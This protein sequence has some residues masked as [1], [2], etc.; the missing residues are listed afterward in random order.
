MYDTQQFIYQYLQKSIYCIFADIVNDPLLD[1]NEVL[2]Q[3][4][5]NDEDDIPNFDSNYYNI[6]DLEKVEYKKF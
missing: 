5:N 6:D 3:Y 4:Y 2:N 1:L